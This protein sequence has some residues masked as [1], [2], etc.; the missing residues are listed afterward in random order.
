M[1]SNDSRCTAFI[2]VRIRYLK[3]RL[4]NFFSKTLNC[5]DVIIVNKILIYSKLEQN[6]NVLRS[7]QCLRKG[8]LKL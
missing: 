3:K 4:K 5:N 7:L 1:P 2:A 8:H 6:Q